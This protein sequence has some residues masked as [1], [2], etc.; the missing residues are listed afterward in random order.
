M[1]AIVSCNIGDCLLNCLKKTFYEL[2]RVQKWR[3]ART[4]C[5]QLRLALALY[6]MCTAFILS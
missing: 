1:R 5:V 4:V 6:N 2:H 3:S